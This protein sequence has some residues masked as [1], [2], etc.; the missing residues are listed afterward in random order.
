M[1]HHSI[2]GMLTHTVVELYYPNQVAQLGSSCCCRKSTPNLF[3][4]WPKPCA[5]YSKYLSL[6]WKFIQTELSTPSI[7]WVLTKMG[8]Q[9]A[10][11]RLSNIFILLKKKKRKK[12]RTYCKS[13][14]FQAK[15]TEK[16]ELFVYKIF[17]C[18]TY[19]VIF[20]CA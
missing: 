9:N 15:K 20:G 6:S 16:S 7:I 17:I 18:S 1:R 12:K 14:N 2:R 4:S 11:D 8:E 5:F 19:V 10:K 3:L 13:D